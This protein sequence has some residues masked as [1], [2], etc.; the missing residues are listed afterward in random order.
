[1]KNAKGH[2][3]L[4][5]GDVMK[6]SFLFWHHFISFRFTFET[7]CS[8]EAAKYLVNDDEDEEKQTFGEAL[9]TAKYNPSFDVSR[10]RFK[11]TSVNARMQ[12]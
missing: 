2:L 6:A 4:A 8:T 1:M 7:H 3:D 10:V 5:V 11:A 9:R 12:V